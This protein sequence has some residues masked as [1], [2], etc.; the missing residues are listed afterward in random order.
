MKRSISLLFAATITLLAADSPQF[1]VASI[2]AS[3][4]QSIR[5]SD[6]GP[7]HKDP[8]RYGFGLATMLDLILVA[9]DVKVFQISS[10]I[11]LDRQAFDLIATVPAGATKEQFREM[12]QNLLKERFALKMHLESREFPA[13]ELVVAKG[14]LKIKEAVSGET[15]SRA[16][17]GWPEFPPNVARMA[18]QN[19]NIGGY[20][21]VR[22]KS[23]LEPFS[24]LADLLEIGDTPI[25]DRTGLTGK[26][27]FTLEFTRDMPGASPDSPPPAPALST[28]LQQQLG[29]QLV[30]KKLPFDVVVV[31]S[32]NKLPTEN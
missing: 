23:Q 3:G 22:L 29:L 19:S 31:E 13:Y 17:T 14:G 2:K 21:V 20:W 12:L 7:G 9:W 27:S 30:S 15:A 4:P 10:S 28:A 18:S 32:F 5:G 1:E 25:V 26:Y 24:L 11:A 8:T 16:E 6:G